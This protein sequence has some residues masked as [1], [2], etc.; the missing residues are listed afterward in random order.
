MQCFVTDFSIA[1]SYVKT[2]NPIKTNQKQ[3]ILK[4]KIQP[5]VNGPGLLLYHFLFAALAQILEQQLKQFF[6]IH[7]LRSFISHNQK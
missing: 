1:V 6:T 3:P 5:G 4:I 2:M 7:M